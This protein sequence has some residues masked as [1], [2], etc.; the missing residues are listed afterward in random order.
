MVGWRLVGEVR[1]SDEGASEEEESVRMS[2][3]SS[4]VCGCVKAGCG[5][6]CSL[7]PLVF[8]PRRLV[9]SCWRQHTTIAHHMSFSV[10]AMSRENASAEVAA[11][12]KAAE[13][14]RLWP[15]DPL[16]LLIAS[17][18]IW[19]ALAAIECTAAALAAQLLQQQRQTAGMT[20][21]SRPRANEQQR[22]NEQQ[23]RPALPPTSPAD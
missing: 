3:S 6:S 7:P 22:D 20:G 8:L 14:V 10:D 21:H 12:C 23:H 4:N 19:V 5:L 9:P 17:V 15:T 18:Q 2:G 13:I 11:L 16:L 1:S